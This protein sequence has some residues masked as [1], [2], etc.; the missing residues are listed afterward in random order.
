VVNLLKKIRV[1]IEGGSIGQLIGL[2][3]ALSIQK[4]YGRDFILVYKRYKLLHTSD[5]NLHNLLYQGESVEIEDFSSHKRESPKQGRIFL[6]IP[7]GVRPY[8]FYFRYLYQLA[9][10]KLAKIFS[11]F[12]ARI[13]RDNKVIVERVPGEKRLI[14]RVTQDTLT[15]KGVYWPGLVGFVINDLHSRFEMAGIP[16]PISKESEPLELIVIHYRLGDMRTQRRWQESHGVIDPNTFA[17]ILEKIRKVEGRDLPVLVI[18]DEIEVARKLFD[19][20]NV[21]NYS[22]SPGADIWVD[23]KLMANA[24][25]FI[26]SFSQVSM[27]AAEIRTVHGLPANFLP[28]N[29]RSGKIARQSR[30]KGIK[31]YRAQYLPL[32]N[33]FY[34]L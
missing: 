9:R 26:G 25:Y 11:Y 15:V 5:F 7:I 1:E 32:D 29:R 21:K 27:V 14:D 12:I 22:F 24:R 20:L 4:K 8:F 10:G 3:M 23:L 16:N 19:R 28:I 30:Q 13:E 2:A 6:R 31:Y 33:E 34:K 17:R 18:S